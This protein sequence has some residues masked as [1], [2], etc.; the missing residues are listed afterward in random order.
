M[1]LKQ[2]VAPK[3]DTLDPKR[4]QARR[5]STLEPKRDMLALKPDIPT[6]V[7]LAPRPGIL[8]VVLSKFFNYFILHQSCCVVSAGVITAAPGL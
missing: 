4:I 3:L 5:L 1:E 2:L 8:K 6:L 7:T